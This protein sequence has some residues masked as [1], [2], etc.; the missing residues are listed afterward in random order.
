[1]KKKGFLATPEWKEL[2]KKESWYIGDTYH[3][4]IGQGDILTTP[5]Q[6]ANYTSVIANNGTLFVPHIVKQIINPE[7]AQTKSI[8]QEIIQQGFINQ[9]HI[10]SVKQGLRSAVT[11]GSARRLSTLNFDVAGKTGTAQVGG[12]KKPHSWFTG[13]APYNN[14]EIVL[15]II[16]ENSG[17]GS[18]AAVPAAKEILQYWFD[19]R[20]N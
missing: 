13:F 5:I 9:E 20:K 2:E 17:E 11:N 7:L 14:P 10:E 6:V 19:N 4:S 3:L 12:N 16:I 8:E 15:T 18:S 1:M